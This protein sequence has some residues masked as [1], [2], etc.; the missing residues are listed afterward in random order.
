MVFLQSASFSEQLWQ[1]A[2]QVDIKEYDEVL[3]VETLNRFTYLLIAS[4]AKHILD[5]NVAQSPAAN[6]LNTGWTADGRT[7]AADF[8]QYMR[9]FYM[10]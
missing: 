8:I 5:G 1:T 4:I 10:K 3:E 7:A 2:S 9:C 6:W